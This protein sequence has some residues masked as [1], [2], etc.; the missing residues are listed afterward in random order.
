MIK[1]Y[2]PRSPGIRHVI[3]L[4]KSSLWKGKPLSKFSKGLLQHGGRNNSGK[5]CMF[6][7]GAAHKKNY[8]NLITTND[9][10]FFGHI[11]SIEHDPNRSALIM[12]VFQKETGALFYLL[13]AQN[14]QVGD[15]VYSGH[16]SQHLTPGSFLALRAIPVGSLIYNIEFFK[17]KGSQYVKAAGSFGKFLTKNI[18]LNF[19]EVRLSSGEVRQCTLDCFASLGSV[20][21]E[22][23]RFFNLGKAGRKRH[24]GKK[25]VPRG[26]AMN[27]IDHPHGGGNGKST[28]GKTCRTPWNQPTKGKP[29]RKKTKK[30]HA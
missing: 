8:R 2:K 26:I 28:S 30:R 13:A 18:T 12:A 3:R 25:P 19:G 4:D 15:V 23:N 1:T 29:T 11:S 21:N 7:R 17:S 27:P 9:Y 10:T 20:S 16:S 5:I 24:L 14:V 22:N 6:N